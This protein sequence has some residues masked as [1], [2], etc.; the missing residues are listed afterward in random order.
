MH[1]LFGLAEIFTFIIIV[2]S[3]L[4]SEGW[5]SQTLWREVGPY[6]GG[7]MPDFAFD[8][9]DSNRVYI[10]SNM[11][12]VFVSDDA[13]DHWTWSNYGATQQSGGIAVDPS[14]SKILYVVGPEGIYQSKDKAKHWEMIYS[15]GN[16]YSGINNLKAGTLKK[17][18]FG[19]PG[20]PI[21]I[22]PAGVVYISTIEGSLLI[23]RDKGISFER[24]VIAEKSVVNMVIPVDEKR[25]VAALYNG[26]VY[27][28]ENEGFTWKNTLLLSDGNLLAL[29]IN[30]LKRKEL[31]ALVSKKPI[32]TRSTSRNYAISL[33]Q[34][35]DSGTSW[36]N[37]NEFTALP[38]IKNRRILDI[39]ID[40]TIIILT[41]RGPLRSVDGGQTWSYSATLVSE[42]DD[43]YIYGNKG[44]W[45]G[46]KWSIYADHR[47]VGRWYISGA[48]AVFRSDDD[49]KTWHYKVK[50]LREQAYWFVKVNPADP[51]I[52]IASDLDHGLVRSPDGGKTWHDVVIVHPYEE[53]DQLRF[54]P[55]DNTYR[56]LY[57]L[58]KHPYPFIAKSTDMGQT[59]NVLKEW[60]EKKRSALTGFALVKGEKV[61]VMYIGEPGVGI[62]I[63][64]DEGSNWK[65]NGKGLPKGKSLNYIHALESDRR[66]NLYI[67]IASRSK[68]EGG[69][70]SSTDKGKTWIPINDGLNSLSIRNKSFE[71]DP[72]NPDTL[73][74][75]AGRAVYV[76]TD[77]GIHWQKKVEH[78]YATAIL[79]EPGN[80]DNVYIGVFTGGGV[81]EQYAAGIY[82][83]LDSGNFFIKMSGNLMQSVGSSYRV[84]DLEYGWKG[85]GGIWAAPNGGGLIYTVS[86]FAQRE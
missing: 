39:S 5:T 37:V 51:D 3:I 52:I 19:Q 71:I 18:I 48:M 56:V 43:G 45:G 2:T 58:F 28:S 40:G 49:G 17:S 23:S 26:G 81:V 60:K 6:A 78:V 50:G 36:K 9:D 29:T 15:K 16:G 74:V 80:S 46:H 69:M 66:G 64:E 13:G 24:V 7:A 70:F 53:C 31:Y 42:E 34:S 27:L 33:Y 11:V 67:G 65:R 59:W 10:T 44:K 75:S 85:T 83:S 68:E 38:V 41:G 82:K 4:C 84:Y 21:S 30:P 54:S 20:Q 55:N 73:W 76:S 57:A 8:P 63:S 32:K 62:W 61:P 35:V 72:N 1:R 77:C 12:G 14:N 79:V 22:G 25:V 47:K 86:P